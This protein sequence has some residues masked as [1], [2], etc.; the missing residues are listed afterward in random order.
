MQWNWWMSKLPSTLCACLVNTSCYVAVATDAKYSVYLLDQPVMFWCCY[1]WSMNVMTDAEWILGQPDVLQFVAV[2]QS[3]ICMCS[4]TVHSVY[5]VYAVQQ[6]SSTTSLLCSTSWFQGHWLLSTLCTVANCLSGQLCY[7]SL[8]FWNDQFNGAD[9]YSFH[10]TCW[11]LSTEVVSLFSTTWMMFSVPACSWLPS[12]SCD[13]WCL[14][15]AL[16]IV[17]YALR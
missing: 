11:C 9:V 1:C 16:M 7:F 13:V 10:G 4:S 14:F 8:C 12:H 15:T 5:A 2:S 17:L 6:F 3:T